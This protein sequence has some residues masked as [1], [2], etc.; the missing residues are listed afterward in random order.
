[1]ST[2][3]RKLGEVM[4][5][6]IPR[7]SKPPKAWL[8]SWFTRSRSEV[9]SKEGS[10][11]VMLAIEMSPFWNWNLLSGWVGVGKGPQGL[12]AREYEMRYTVAARACRSVQPSAI[13]LVSWISRGI[14]IAVLPLA[15]PR[16]T[17]SFFEANG[18]ASACI[19]HKDQR[20][21]AGGTPPLS[22]TALPAG[23]TQKTNAGDSP[24]TVEGDFAVESKFNETTEQKRLNEA[25]DAQ[26]PWKK[27]GPYLSERQWGTVREDYSQDGNAWNY[28]SH[29]QSRSRTY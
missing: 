27:W 11:R 18:S 24:E 4:G 3:G 20:H 15:P 19:H 9:N 26:V 25:R 13:R 28:F 5:C 22:R 12:A 6:S 23:Q 16:L 10:L 17:S 29:D 21:A 1:M 8:K 2:G 14:R 7:P